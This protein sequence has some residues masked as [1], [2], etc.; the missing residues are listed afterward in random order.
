MP[1]GTRIGRYTLHY[2]DGSREEIPIVYGQDVRD[3]WTTPYPQKVTNGKVAWEG[4]NAC[5]KEHG[6]RIR[7][8]LGNWKQSPSRGQGNSDRFRKTAARP[9]APFCVGLTLEP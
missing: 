3:W 1:D 4:D 2:E 5:A 7:L 8:Y 6:H 9:T